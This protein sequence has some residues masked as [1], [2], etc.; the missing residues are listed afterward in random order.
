MISFLTSLSYRSA[1][2]QFEVRNE[3]LDQ[4]GFA[5][6]DASLVWEPD[7]ENWRIGLHGKNL[8]NVRYKVAGYNF[9]DLGLEG[10]VTAFYGNPRT[11]TL[12]AEYRF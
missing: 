1:A 10:N 5:L 11:V 4:P 7:S 3:F 8:A 12:T 9:P 6:W 2:S